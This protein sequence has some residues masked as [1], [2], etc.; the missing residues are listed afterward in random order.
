MSVYAKDSNNQEIL[1][2]AANATSHDG[3]GKSPIWKLLLMSY[4][5]QGTY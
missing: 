4:N 2:S 5:Q 1:L 3:M